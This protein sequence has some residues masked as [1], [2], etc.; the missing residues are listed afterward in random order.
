[1]RV[2]QVN[3]PAQRDACLARLCADTFGSESGLTP[4]LRFAGVTGVLFEQQAARVLALVDDDSRPLA[5]ALLVLD[6]ANQ[7]MTP[8]LMLDLDTPAGSSPAMVLIHELAQRA[9]LR[10]DAN[11]DAEQQRLTHAGLGRWFD[12]PH[13]IRIGLNDKHPATAL[14]DIATPLSVDDTAVAQGF[15][16]DR[17]LFERYKQRFTDSLAN[18]PAAL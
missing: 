18:F 14:A 11:D 7:G 3:E 16:R 1:M 15:K 13:G 17:T 6:K 5:L 10:V 8:M 9:P 4:L 2:I 12:G